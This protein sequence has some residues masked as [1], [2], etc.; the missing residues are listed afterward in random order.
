MLDKE[1]KFYLENQSELAKQYFSRYII[2]KEQQVLGDYATEIEAV[3][4]AQNE[5][6]LKIGTFLVQQCLPGVENHTQF[7]HSRAIFVSI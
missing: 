5:M 6:K 4:A 2:I 3:L 1:F 7:F